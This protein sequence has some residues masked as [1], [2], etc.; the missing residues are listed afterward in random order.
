MLG[1]TPFNLAWRFNASCKMKKQFS[2]F[3]KNKRIWK[4]VKEPFRKSLKKFAVFIYIYIFYNMIEQHSYFYVVSKKQ[5]SYVS[6]QYL[7]WL[8]LTDFIK[9]YT[10]I[11]K[12]YLLIKTDKRF[13]HICMTVFVYEVKSSALGICILRNCLN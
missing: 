11:W 2:F 1:I 10:W 13:T 4:I 9:K 12:N 8:A 5:I 7:N 3:L 6:M